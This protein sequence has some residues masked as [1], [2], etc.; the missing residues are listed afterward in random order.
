ML[1]FRTV[2]T[3]FTIAQERFS[4]VRHFGGGGISIFWHRPSGDHQIVTE[5]NYAAEDLAALVLKI[6]FDS[7]MDVLSLH[8]QI[9]IVNAFR[10]L[11]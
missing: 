10:V 9:A 6:A 8:E 11:R 7:E 5:R 2:R 4:A 3:E 1:S